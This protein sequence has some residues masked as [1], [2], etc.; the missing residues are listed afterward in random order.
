[1]THCVNHYVYV[2]AL[3]P[4]IQENMF[5]YLH[6]TKLTASLYLDLQLIFHANPKLDNSDQN[7]LH[8]STPGEMYKKTY[9][10][11]CVNQLF[12]LCMKTGFQNIKLYLTR[13]YIT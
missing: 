11:M 13:Q 7:N 12:Y 3:K 9:S 5:L 4:Q 6:E 10:K 8:G 1:M 2:H